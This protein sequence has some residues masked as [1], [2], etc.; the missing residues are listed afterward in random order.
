[1]TLMLALATAAALAAP[2]TLRK[3]GDCKLQVA[4]AFDDDK[5]VAVN[6]GNASVERLTFLECVGLYH[7]AVYVP[8]K[9]L[10]SSE[11]D[12]AEKLAR[13]EKSRLAQECAKLDPAFE[14]ALAEE[15]LSED[16]A[17]WPEY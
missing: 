9:T 1:M 2:S 13:L 17:Q 3:S 11:E 15:G 6:L 4:G 16:L 12:V 14:K 8:R 7:A 5:A 10:I